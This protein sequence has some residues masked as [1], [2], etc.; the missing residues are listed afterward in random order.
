[1]VTGGKSAW[2]VHGNWTVPNLIPVVTADSVT[3]TSGAGPT[4]TFAL[5][6]SDSFGAT[7]FSTT[8]VWF[9]ETF[10]S[11]A[12]NSC[13]LYYDRPADTIYLLNDGA[14]TW[15]PGTPG[16]GSTLQNNQCRVD[17]SGSSVVL[18]G[19]TLTLN[20]AMTFKPPYAG[21]KNVYMYG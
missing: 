4:Q 20:L 8:W 3:P 10:A 2:Q 9:N 17:L 12:A 7:D 18:S 19:N 16:T 6:Y 11:T 15:M 14:G 1:N 21:A 13:M 5:Q